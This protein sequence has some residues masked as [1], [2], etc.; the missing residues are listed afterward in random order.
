MW[1]VDFGTRKERTLFW[2]A[3]IQTRALLVNVKK[4]PH[5]EM[6]PIL[7]RW[8]LAKCTSVKRFTF[9]KVSAKRCNFRVP[10]YKGVPLPWIKW[11]PSLNDDCWPT[12]QVWKDSLSE[13][14]VLKYVTLGLLFTRRFPSYEWNYTH[15]LTMTAS[16]V[17]AC[18]KVSLAE[19]LVLNYATLGF[20][21]IRGFPSHEWKET[22]P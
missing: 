13:K 10:I 20:P 15:P 14:W 4:D 7:Y 1:Y 9:R 19:K 8:R 12:I 17:Y 3:K 6:T 21:F 16:Q 5:N 11:N 2:S 18:V 22:L